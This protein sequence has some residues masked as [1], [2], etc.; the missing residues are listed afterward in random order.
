M[1]VRNQFYTFL[2][3]GGKISGKGIPFVQGSNEVFSVLIASVSVPVYVSLCLL[4]I[5]AWFSFFK[6]SFT[7]TFMIIGFLEDKSSLKF[8]GSNCYK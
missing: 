6:N 7:I 2:Y 3:S 8:C 5:C 1:L 4:F